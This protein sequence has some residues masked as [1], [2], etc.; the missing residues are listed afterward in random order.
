M[1]QVS[2]HANPWNELPQKWGKIWAEDRIKDV[3]YGNSVTEAVDFLY[4]MKAF[5]NTAEVIWRE[6]GPLYYTNRLGLN[7][8]I[9]ELRER[10]PKTWHD[11]LV[12]YVKH[13]Y[14]LVKYIIDT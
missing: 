13:V 7:D 1:P 10:I 3:P 11:G 6:Q 5:Y 14:F 12:D 9:Q 2:L 4:A 8:F